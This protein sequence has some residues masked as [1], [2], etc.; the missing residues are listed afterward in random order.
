[1]LVFSYKIISAFPKSIK[2]PS[3]TDLGIINNATYSIIFQF[4]I[5][6]LQAAKLRIKLNMYDQPV[7]MDKH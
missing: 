4:Q 7:V 5:P 2:I 6:T 1:M 3:K